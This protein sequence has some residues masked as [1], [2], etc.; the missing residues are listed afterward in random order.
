MLYVKYPNTR[1]TQLPAYSFQHSSLR[2]NTH[3]PPPLSS[4]FQVTSTTSIQV[5]SRHK[6][7]RT[8]SVLTQSVAINLAKSPVSRTLYIW[9]VVELFLLLAVIVA[10]VV[11]VYSLQAKNHVRVSLESGTNERILYGTF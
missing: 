2:V 11:V 1:I 8:D 7:L 4:R 10:A 6:Q 3:L 5:Q 9:F